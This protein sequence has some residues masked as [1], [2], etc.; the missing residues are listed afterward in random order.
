MSAGR[1]PRWGWHRLADDA[2]RKVVA[3]TP[4]RPGD[5]VVDLGAGCGALTRHL[6]AAGAEVIAVEL[7]PERLA[8]LRRRFAGHPVTVVR[9]DVRD[10]RLPRRPFRVVA[11]P[12]F[13]ATDAILRRL[14]GRGSALVSADLVLPRHAVE[15]WAGPSAP[16]AGRWRREWHAGSGGALPRRWFRPAAPMPIEVLRIRRR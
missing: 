11:N 6:V 16:G 4:V 14:L 2:A 15:R 8:E 10:L 13:E 1:R 12:P 5:L 7:H 3:R 9:A